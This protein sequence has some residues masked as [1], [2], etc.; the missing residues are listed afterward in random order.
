MVPYAQI[1]C[2]MML[3]RKGNHDHQISECR[4]ELRGIVRSRRDYRR[5]FITRMEEVQRVNGMLLDDGV[6]SR[7]QLA[8]GEADRVIDLQHAQIVQLGGQTPLGLAHDL[9]TAGVSIAGTTPDVI[10]LAEDRKRFADLCN[11]IDI[12]QPPNGTAI[13]ADEA[14]AI[15]DEI[16]FPVLVR[17]S[18]VLGGRAMRI[19]YT[20]GAAVLVL[21]IYGGATVAR[22]CSST[23]AAPSISLIINRRI[24]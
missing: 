13:S 21:G 14:T 6:F 17:P 24:S 18:Y 19:V 12:P 16:G 1:R 4:R 8:R 15:V 10:D 2:N 22:R 5:A 20:V 11:R 3:Y 9:E 7:A 23:P